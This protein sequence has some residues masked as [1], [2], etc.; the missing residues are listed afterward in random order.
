MCVFLHVEGTKLYFL[1]ICIEEN[2]AIK[3]PLKLD[4]HVSLI[5]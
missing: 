4:M 5:S 1:G 2:L 3:F